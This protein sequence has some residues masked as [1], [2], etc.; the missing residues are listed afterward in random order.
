MA[1]R[2]NEEQVV[3][4]P[5]KNIRIT[6]GKKKSAGS[7]LH[8]ED[9]V[10][11]QQMEEMKA[12][13]AE[14]DARMEAI[15]STSA[16]IEFETNGTIITANPLFLQ[17]VKYELNEIQG[18][19]HSMFVDAT[20][21]QSR[22]YQ[23]FWENLRNGFPQTGEFERIAKDGTHI[24]L[25]G[26][27][28]P[29]KNEVGKVVKVIKLASN[30]TEE[31][32]RNA[33]FRGQLDA[34]NKSYAV[35]EFNLN[36]TIIS[37]NDNF[38]N[39][40]GYSLGEIQGRHHSM[41]VEGEHKNSPEYKAF[42]EKLNRGEFDAGT[43]RR[44]GKNNK[45]CYIQATYNPIFDLNG[46]P[47]KVVKYATDI[48]E[49]THAL[50]AVSTFV[51]QLRNGN[52]DADI[53]LTAEGDI[54]QMIRD[55][56][57]LRDTLKEII[58]NV[59]DVVMKAGNEGNL[60]ARLNLTG[61]E[62]AWKELIDSI[63][64]LLQSIADPVLEFNAIIAEMAKGDLTRRFE[65]Q[66]KGDI[67]NMAQS[68]NTAVENLNQLLAN[69]G[70][71]AD[72]VAGSSVTM[73]EKSEGMKKN[74]NEVASAIS[75][76]AKGAQDQA[77]RTDES[78]KLVNEVL[79]T[80]EA[81]EN[82]ADIIN[83]AAE[84]GQ[85]SCEDGIKIISRLVE[86]MTGISDSA[87]LTSESI[88]ILTQRAEEIGRTLN[89]ITD[90]AAQTNLLALN[91]AI[92]AARAGDAGRGF[93]VVAEEIRKLAEDSRKSAIDIEKIIGDVQKDTQSASK[94]I[95]NMAGSVK[96]GNKASKEA[97][98]IFQEIAK[99]SKD[100]LSFSKE[101]QEATV[102]QKSSIDTVVKNI[103]QIVVVAEETAAGTQQVASSSQELNASMDEITRSSNQLS[104][105]AAELQAGVNQ[106]KLI[107]TQNR[108]GRNL[109]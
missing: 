85:Q 46:N 28:T 48:T 92:E 34:V 17:T 7:G 107:G 35:I 19:H 108:N 52:F 91:A 5:E 41:F 53:T 90:I 4:V 65:M 86:N 43:Y 95:E 60:N 45:E 81:M 109:K 102:G 76:M 104:E 42:W 62:G 82:K 105:I 103:E 77:S 74:T 106:F 22:N 30:V 84:R 66:A 32:L 101:I 78:S 47:F 93:A 36:G 25:L 21:A 51:G 79:K 18:Q 11:Q 70:E 72:V 88:K 15:N 55:N 68:L 100:T 83:K 40:V 6:R 3:I 33:N 97:E 63:N 29:I 13:K 69:I 98:V 99:S 49:F 26:N 16:F 50:K 2:K 73:L 54:G 9:A 67:L 57:K 39:V 61:A 94:A 27:Y 71:N 23:Q 1:Q 44:I 58:E 12:L 64:Q 14:M 24:W 96:E 80:S 38:L 59:S 75:Q 37:A 20:Y 56:L 89:V 8:A 31:K 10:L 87:N